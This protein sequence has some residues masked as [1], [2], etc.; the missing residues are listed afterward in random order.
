MITFFT[1]AKPFVG[2]TR[3]SQLNALASWK[4]VHPEAEVI[5]FGQSEGSAE[6][7]TALNLRYVP[8]VQTNEF[9][10]PLIS[11]MF[12]AAQEQGR[13][14]LQAY[15]NADIVLLDDFLPAVNRV[16]LSRFLLGGQRW[17]LDLDGALS[18][19]SDWIG[20]LRR[21]IRERGVCHPPSGS[22]YF[23]YRR[24][25]WCDIPPFAVGRVGWD[26]WMIYRCLANG[27]PVIDASSVITVV[28]QN[29]APYTHSK[30]I[31]RSGPWSGPESDYNT[32]LAGAGGRI[33]FFHA[34]FLLT[35]KGLR[36]KGSIRYRMESVLI[37]PILDPR[38]AWLSPILWM[39]RQVKW[40]VEDR[41]PPHVVLSKSFRFVQ[42]R[43]I[44]RIKS[45][46]L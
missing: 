12:K 30:R 16:S 14:N 1:T 43:I 17:D 40:V 19:E 4:Q 35:S 15:V 32:E 39:L 21:A 34:N 7:A 9:G 3:T 5:L 6:A 33:T 27:V 13:H 22:D 46:G 37:L 20:H 28:H 23:V 42:R 29:H 38:Y 25:L 8:N 44:G 18:L 45:Q 10:T 24:G 2:R 36:P 31:G 11:A 41:I 26:N